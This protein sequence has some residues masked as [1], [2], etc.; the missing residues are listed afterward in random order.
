MAIG[1]G[2]PRR[3]TKG[4]ENTLSGQGPRVASSRHA[5]QYAIIDKRERARVHRVYGLARGE[6]KLVE[7][8]AGA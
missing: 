1:G 7:E 2:W 6:I 3:E 4:Q 8:A 5:V